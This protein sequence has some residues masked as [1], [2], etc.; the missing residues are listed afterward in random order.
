MKTVWKLGV[1]LTGFALLILV[2]ERTGSGRVVRELH[3]M[4][5]AFVVI[6]VLSLIRLRL[7][8]QSW[9]LALREDGVNSNTSELIFLRLASQGIG[10]LT[11]LGPAASEPM[12]IK[13]LQH[14]RGSAT[15]ATLVDTGAYWMKRWTGFDR[16]VHCSHGYVCA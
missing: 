9:A 12:K 3:A 7:Q 4:S 14:H 6:L 13:M 2:V 10:Y 1:L 5:G 15:V 11:V 8:T 16:R